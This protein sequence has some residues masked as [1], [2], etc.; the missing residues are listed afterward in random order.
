MVPDSLRRVLSAVLTRTDA[1]VLAG[2]G[3]LVLVWIALCLLRRAKA[4]A[5][6]VLPAAPLPNTPTPQPRPATHPSL[7]HP[8]PRRVNVFDDPTRVVEVL[9]FDTPTCVY[10]ASF[11]LV[12]EERER[13][14]RR[15]H[16]IRR[17]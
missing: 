12:C 13:R 8:R 5:A 1:V 16:I 2:V 14:A 11:S 17:R 9:P 15:P 3:A 6:I 4:A 7:E 10:P